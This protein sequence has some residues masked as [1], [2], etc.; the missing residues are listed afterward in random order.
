[1]LEL[2]KQLIKNIIDLNPESIN[3]YW[4]Y[5][6]DYILKIATLSLETCTIIEHKAI[7]LGLTVK[8]EYDM[9]GTKN[10]FLYC[11]AEDVEV[12]KLK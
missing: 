7:A 6:G 9:K 11:V 1:M 10:Y 3:M 2:H 4:G 8:V 12:Y 5:K